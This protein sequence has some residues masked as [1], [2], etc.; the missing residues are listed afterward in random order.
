VLPS[1]YGTSAIDVSSGKLMDRCSRR[2]RAELYFADAECSLQVHTSDWM[3]VLHNVDPDDIS[4]AAGVALDSW[5][6]VKTPRKVWG[7]LKRDLANVMQFS[8][9]IPR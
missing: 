8:Q 2:A 5:F 3:N 4:R 7:K 6:N 9:H 1:W